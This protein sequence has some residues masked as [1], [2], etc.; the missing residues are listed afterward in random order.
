M[1]IC[2]APILQ[3]R[4]LNKHSITRMMYIQMEMLSAIKMYLR[5]KKS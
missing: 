4:A 2:K 1:N 5:K 3:L